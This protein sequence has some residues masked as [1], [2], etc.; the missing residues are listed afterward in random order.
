MNPEAKPIE[1]QHLDRRAVALANALASHQARFEWARGDSTLALDLQVGPPLA[2]PDLQLQFSDGDGDF[3][4]Q[5]SNALLQQLCSPWRGDDPATS[6]PP[7]LLR[8]ALSPLLDW[9]G[10]L[11]GLRLE[12]PEALKPT[13]LDAVALQLCDGVA[14]D[15]RPLAAI[16]CSAAQAERLS[17]AV[18][19]LTAR[20]PA[21]DAG[22][23]SAQVGLRLG[24]TALTPAEYRGLARG[25]VLLLPTPLAAGD[26]WITLHQG[27]R[28]LACASLRG[29]RALVI[30][31]PVHASLR[32]LEETTMNDE[33]ENDFDDEFGDGIDFDDSAEFDDATE[34][35]TAT[36]DPSPGDG[37]AVDPAALDVR[38]DFDLG[39]LSLTVDEIAALR[40]GTCLELDMPPAGRV[41]VKSGGR[42]V[43][44]GELVQIEDRL[45]VRL[46]GLVERK[47]G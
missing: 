15:S 18:R 29:D 4:V 25:D 32:A 35:D 10:K 39:H 12:T 7:Q 47:D 31:E 11:A 28:A 6:L 8:A 43:A 22:P 30:T 45:G 13:A 17:V 37:G 34:A 27:D 26:P 5:L 40:A 42:L 36:D 20:G 19:A 33:F 24:A 3:Q 16:V 1:L 46:T 23:L 21:L 9:L 14:G 44:H 38:L 41:N 2:A